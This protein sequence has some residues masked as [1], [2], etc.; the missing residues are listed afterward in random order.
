MNFKEFI[1]NE[2]KLSDILKPIPQSEKHHA[3]GDVFTHTRMVRSRLPI[4]IDFLKKEQQNTD[5]IFSN[6]DLNYTPQE[7]KLLKLSAWFHDMG[8]AT[9]TKISS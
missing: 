8:K 4:A 6:L 2:M 5:S 1:Q 9:A 7:I 3:E